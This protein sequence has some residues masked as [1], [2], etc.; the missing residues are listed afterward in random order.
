MEVKMSQFFTKVSKH[1]GISGFRGKL[2]WNIVSPNWDTCLTLHSIW[3]LGK[4][5]VGYT[6]FLNAV[7]EP[8]SKLDPVSPSRACGWAR[9]PLLHKCICILTFRVAIHILNSHSLAPLN[10]TQ[11]GE[12]DS[13]QNGFKV[14]VE[15]YYNDTV[16]QRQL[17]DTSS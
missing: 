2:H 11:Q 15:L 14:Q 13:L 7:A 17:V 16:A 12:R 1:F 9:E 4:T 10:K 5:I 8:N 6:K 3:F